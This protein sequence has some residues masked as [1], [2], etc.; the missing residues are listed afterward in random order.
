MKPKQPAGP[1]MTLG[2]MRE[3]GMRPLLA[4]GDARDGYKIMPC[5]RGED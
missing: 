2:N 4:R 5:S 1:P 3:L